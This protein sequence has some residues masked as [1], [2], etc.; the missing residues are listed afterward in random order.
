MALCGGERYSQGS[1]DLRHREPGKETKLHQ[2][3][4]QWFLARKFGESFVESE[5]IVTGLGH[6]KG[7]VEIDAPAVAAVLAAFVSGGRYR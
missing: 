6:G 3:G 1:G 4:F 5:E 2:L 7:L